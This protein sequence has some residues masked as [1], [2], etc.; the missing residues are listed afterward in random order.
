MNLLEF[1]PFGSKN[2]IKR[3][4]LVMASGMSDR[5]MR[6]CIE[7]LRKETPIV[8]SAERAGLFPP[9]DRGGIESLYCPGKSESDNHF[10]QSAGGRKAIAD[11]SW[12]VDLERFMM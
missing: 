2:A 6:R 7:E 8:E 5:E 10:E 4:D 12:T 9:G 1:I 3:T 11:Y